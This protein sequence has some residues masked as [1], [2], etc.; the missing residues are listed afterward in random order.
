MK[1]SHYL[2]LFFFTLSSCDFSKKER[3]LNAE[4]EKTEAA[5]SSEDSTEV[6][7]FEIK[8]ALSEKANR[9]LKDNNYSHII[10]AEFIGYPKNPIVE[11][12]KYEFYNETGRLIVGSKRIEVENTGIAKFNDCKVSKKLLQLFEGKT[13][14]VR[15]N[16]VNGRKSLENYSIDYDY[17]QENIE[18]LRNKRTIINGKLI[19][20]E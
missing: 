20:E 6:P 13:Y 3:V 5:Q 16:I 1:N 2:I 8:L 19:R 17:L 4:K 11:K 18:R 7:D 15:I 10:V 9:I 12:F 14:D